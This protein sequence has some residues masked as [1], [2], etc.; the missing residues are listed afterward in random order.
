M[1]KTGAMYGGALYQLAAEEGLEQQILDELAQV[2]RLLA[3]NP[4]Y[5][6]L[7]ALPSV[8][9]AQRCAALDEAFGGRVQPYLLNFLKILC[10]K[11][12]IRSLPACFQ[13]YRAR[14][15]QA[16]GILEATAVTAVPMTQTQTAALQ[17]KLAALTGKT[18][19]LTTRVQ[20]GCL[21]GVRLEVEGTQ[22]DGTVQNRLDE[23]RRLLAAT[24]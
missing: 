19:A 6:K 17:Q 12:E 9:K 18:I 10:E 3:E 21:G 22:L 4:D 1:T 23:V 5:A 11:G 14:Y 2:N 16:H 8:P 20:P 24:L 15:N 13:E 7:L